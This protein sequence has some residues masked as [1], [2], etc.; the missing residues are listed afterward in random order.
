MENQIHK[1]I[2]NNIKKLTLKNVKTLYILKH[3]IFCK[4]TLKNLYI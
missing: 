3:L 1:Q 4:I 2:S